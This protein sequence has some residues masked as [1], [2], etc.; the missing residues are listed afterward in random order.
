MANHTIDATFAQIPV[1]TYTLSVTNAGT[2]IG[3]VSTNP[4]GSSFHAGTLVTLTAAPD[5]SSTFAGWSGGCSGTSSPVSLVMNS[6]T[7][8][9]ATFTLKTYSIS[10]TAGTNGLIS[11][12]GTVMVN[13]G[14]SQSFTITPRAGYKVADV[15]VDG[16]SVGSVNSYSFA[17]VKANHK[18]EALF[19]RSAKTLH[20]RK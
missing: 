9:T 1:S 12:S 16:V 10:A 7:N 3:T 13:S 11:P 8:V 4:S 20:K 5:T 18:I 6:N 2:G 15:K 14:S 19:S 17:N